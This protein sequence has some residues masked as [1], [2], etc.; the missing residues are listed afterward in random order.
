MHL[1][2]R[3]ISTIETGRRQLPDADLVIKLSTAL[4]LTES[5]HSALLEALAASNYSIQ[6]PV[7]TGAQEL[8]FLHSLVSRLGMLNKHTL[9][10]MNVLMRE[11]AKMT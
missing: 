6:L 5:Q 8:R 3:V 11:D 4:D 7:D 10:R 9:E 2:A 1:S